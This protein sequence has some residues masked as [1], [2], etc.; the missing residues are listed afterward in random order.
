MNERYNVYEAAVNKSTASVGELK[1]I[2]RAT[3]AA[4]IGFFFIQQFIGFLLSVPAASELFGSDRVFYESVSL[5]VP[6]FSI[7]VPFLLTG[8][9]LQDKLPND[10]LPL[11]APKQ[12]FKTVL[13]VPAGVMLC[14]MGS[15]VSSFIN[16]ILQ[17]AG[18][19]L[20]APDLSVPDSPFAI[21][22]YLLRLTIGA[23][24]VE[25][26]CM[27]GVVM[28]SLRRY[29][30]GFAIAMSAMV[31]GLLHC[32]LVQAP[33]AFIAGAVIGYFT[34]S[35]GSIWTGILIHMFNNSISG[36]F[37]VMMMFLEE[38]R[39]ELYSNVLI[40]FALIFG[41][42]C[43]LLYAF[44]FGKKRLYRS[45]AK[46]TL[47]KR[48]TTYIFTVPMVVAIGLILWQMHYYVSL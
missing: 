31:F 36:I 27:R 48:L 11:E 1:M 16:G 20:T 21:V 29:G 2:S 9:Y 13:A 23:A 34:I 41:A 43:A 15:F 30:D 38:E 39:A 28:Q 6:I 46:L 19:E 47:Q 4:I 5:L 44:M 40:N 37:G 24:L 33:F 32:N 18:A 8:R 7:A 45:E 12:R 35:T 42:I 10:L 25:E 17:D 3:G 14:L 26:I 22:I